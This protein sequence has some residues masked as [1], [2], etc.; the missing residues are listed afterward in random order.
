[1][2]T[3]A[4]T[5]CSLPGSVCDCGR[6]RTFPEESHGLVACDDAC[7]DIEVVSTMVVIHIILVVPLLC[8]YSISVMT[9]VSTGI[10]LQPKGK[11]HPCTGTEV[12]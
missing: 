4:Y 2:L 5:L 8:G 1:M 7:F 12:L 10:V 9:V 3:D 11:G 6:S